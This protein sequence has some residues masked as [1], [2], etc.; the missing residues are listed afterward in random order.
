MFIKSKDKYLI[1]EYQLMYPI[2]YKN[3]NAVE[4]T[5]ETIVF[6]RP[7]YAHL[8]KDFIPVVKNLN[9]TTVFLSLLQDMQSNIEAEKIG[10]LSS[11]A[12]NMFSLLSKISNEL[13]TNILK[14]NIDIDAV[15]VEAVNKMFFPNERSQYS[16]LLLAQDKDNKNFLTADEIQMLDSCDVYNI[17]ESLRH[18]FFLEYQ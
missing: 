11:E 5:L 16:H 17:Y 1:G 7:K 3:E 8:T 4:Y 10:N 13:Q 2:K 14:H 15:F 18:F 12:D 9:K 6:H